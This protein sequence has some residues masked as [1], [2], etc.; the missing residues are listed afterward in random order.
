MF[1]HARLLEAIHAVK[2]LPRK[3]WIEHGL[4]ERQVETVGSHSFGTAALAV[5]LYKG[6]YLHED[7]DFTRLLELA[8][9]HDI[10]ES[11]IGDMTPAGAVPARKKAEME[12]NAVHAVM[13]GLPGLDALVND[14]AS[15]V[16]GHGEETMDSVPALVKQIDKLDMMIKALLY[17]RDTGKDMSDFHGNPEKYLSD[18]Q[19]LAFFASFKQSIQI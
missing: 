2:H 12:S 8:L 9:L 10:G 5:V 3:G 4:G 19:L 18:E 1:V 17:E 13:D 16:A 7:V 11:V 6:G 14:L 15:L